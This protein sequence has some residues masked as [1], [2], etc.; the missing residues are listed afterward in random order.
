MPK[1][2]CYNSGS[3]LLWRF[4]VRLRNSSHIEI[5][6][7]CLPPISKNYSQFQCARPKNGAVTP[8]GFGS[9]CCRVW[10]PGFYSLIALAA[11]LAAQTT[12]RMFPPYSAV[13]SIFSFTA[14]SISAYI[15]SSALSASLVASRPWASCDPL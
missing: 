9:R 12:R 2:R 1:G 15:A 8:R 14:A 7:D 10:K 5:V 3:N 13:P 4:S 11:W 6:P